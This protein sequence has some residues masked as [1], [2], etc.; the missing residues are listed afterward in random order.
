MQRVI[1]NSRM[2]LAVSFAAILLFNAVRLCGQI[3]TATLTGSVT[4]PTGA[5]VPGAVVEAKNKATQL[6]RTATTD[7]S[8]EYVIPDL[9]PAH[10]SLTF[11]STGSRH[12]SCRI[13]NS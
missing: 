10:Y 7:S 13:S 2:R 3:S 6:V 12:L 5:V 1:Q 11:H 8:G 4:D 9:A